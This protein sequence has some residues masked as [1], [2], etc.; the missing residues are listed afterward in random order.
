MY[1]NREDFKKI[2]PI[3][4]PFIMLCGVL[5]QTIYY[6]Y[7]NI[8]ITYYLEFTEVLTLFLNDLLYYGSLMFFVGVFI[9][10]TDSKEEIM[11]VSG[12]QNNIIKNKDL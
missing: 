11:A 2:V 3:V 8:R 9:F 4:T 12:M 6:N 10:I 7:F 5:K 1:F